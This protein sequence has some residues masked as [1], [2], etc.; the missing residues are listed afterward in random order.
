MSPIRDNQQKATFSPNASNLEDRKALNDQ[1]DIQ[2]Q[3]TAAS[4]S[5]SDQD[6]CFS[7]DSLSGSPPK[8]SLKSLKSQAKLFVPT[9]ELSVA[10]LTTML[11]A[12]TP[13]PGKDCLAGI[14]HSTLGG[15]VLNL[16][17]MDGI[18]YDGQWYTAVEITIPELSATTMTESV[19]SGDAEAITADQQKNFHSLVQA[20]RDFKPAMV[21][22]P[23]ANGAQICVEFCAAVDPAKLCREFSRCG[24][25][26]RG[27]TCRW[28][29]AMMELFMINFVLA[30]WGP[31][32]STTESSQGQAKAGRWMPSRPPMPPPETSDGTPTA[33]SFGKHARVDDACKSEA[34]KALAP[35]ARPK[36]PRLVSKKRWSDIQDESDDDLCSLSFG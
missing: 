18:S 30:S 9:E 3:T 35:D 27:A 24:S 5:G 34:I 12:C 19:T 31:W 21:L 6:R 28:E 25:C 17:M 29:H 10:D 1:D 36:N 33:D 14:I 15:E 13:T 16:N 11:P 2:S 8:T 23:P 4:D 32:E 26:P 22:Q 20:L 7:G